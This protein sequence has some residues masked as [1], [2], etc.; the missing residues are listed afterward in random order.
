[1][2]QAGRRIAS[3]EFSLAYV[4]AQTFALYEALLAKKR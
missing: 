3:E 1:M 2:G 4:V